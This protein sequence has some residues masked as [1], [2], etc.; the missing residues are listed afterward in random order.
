MLG[1]LS[2]PLCEP[3]CYRSIYKSSGRKSWKRC[4]LH[5]SKIKNL[6]VNF[7]D[8]TIKFVYSKYLANY[9]NIFRCRIL[10]NLLSNKFIDEHIK[11]RV[12]VAA[13]QSRSALESTSKHQTAPWCSVYK[14]HLIEEQF[15]EQGSLKPS[16]RSHRYYYM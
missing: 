5:V 1:T 11:S 3:S 12:R 7:I 13:R 6:A 9:V 15:V 10:F 14:C 4:H 16:H 8:S 2:V